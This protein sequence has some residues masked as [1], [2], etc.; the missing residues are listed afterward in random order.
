M[1]A[2]RMGTL[3]LAVTA[4]VGG[5][6]GLMILPS[7]VEARGAA[8]SHV[9]AVPYNNAAAFKRAGFPATA[10]SVNHTADGRLSWM[11]TPAE[12]QRQDMFRENYLRPA[13]KRV[14]A[15]IADGSRASSSQLFG[16]ADTSTLMVSPLSLQAQ[17]QA[18]LYNKGSYY[19]TCP[20][21]E[22]NDEYYAQIQLPAGAMITGLTGYGYDT[23]AVDDADYYVGRDC[24]GGSYGGSGTAPAA[25]V[26]AG[27][28]GGTYAVT[29]STSDYTIDN[30]D[31][32]YYVVA[33][34]SEGSCDGANSTYGVAI[35]WKRQISPAPATATFLDVPV[36]STFHREVEALVAAGVTGG[37]GGGNY[38]PSANVTR[39]QMAA[40]LSRALG[41]HWESF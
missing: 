26:T 28:V 30:T 23:S 3:A 38:C 32:S 4:V 37:C 9:V 17:T 12:L 35:R 22:G 31:C 29:S 1:K 41:L 10:L 27:Y 36:G 34:L 33:D 7:S 6:V 40:F 19:L 20:N 5:A 11:A 16:V 21:T 2:I 18:T 15:S 24:P 39:G 13:Q 14:A 8:E 25:H